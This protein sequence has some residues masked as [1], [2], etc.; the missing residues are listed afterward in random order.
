MNEN[1][2]TVRS[3][4][5]RHHVSRSTMGLSFQFTDR[6]TTSMKAKTSITIETL[7]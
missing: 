2:D 4:I 7:F 1:T 6:W 5:D 3:F